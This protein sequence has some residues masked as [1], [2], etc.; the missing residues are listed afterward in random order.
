MG[1][2]NKR[3]ISKYSE[4]YFFYNEENFVGGEDFLDDT[5]TTVIGL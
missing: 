5:Q 4:K 3:A 1:G 2:G